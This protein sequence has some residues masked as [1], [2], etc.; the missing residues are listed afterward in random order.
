MHKKT[1]HGH[2]FYTFLKH[3]RCFFSHIKRNHQYIHQDSLWMDMKLQGIYDHFGAL[4]I[5]KDIYI[6]ATGSEKVPKHVFARRKA[7]WQEDC[8]YL[9]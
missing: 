4:R 1:R 6:T 9:V 8:A 2:Y 5:F 3:F 7:V